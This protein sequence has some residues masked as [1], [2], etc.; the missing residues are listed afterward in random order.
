M[1]S[2]WM[3]RNGFSERGQLEP[4][5][6]KLRS[7]LI[8]NRAAACFG[9]YR[10]SNIS[11]HV[12]CDGAVRHWARY[13]AS[14]QQLPRATRRKIK[15][16][17]NADDPNMWLSLTQCP[18]Q[19]VVKC[20]LHPSAISWSA[21]HSFLKASMA[22]FLKASKAFGS[23]MAF[24]SYPSLHPFFSEVSW[25]CLSH[26]VNTNIT[27]VKIL[28]SCSQY[29]VSESLSITFTTF[30]ITSTQPGR[31]NKSWF[32]SFLAPS[33]TQGRTFKALSPETLSSTQ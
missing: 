10:L 26:A 31:Q 2:A 4:C 21:L 32:F 18:S 33:T 3:C 6:C 22:T 24:L 27:W 28:K 25:P 29:K 8:P 19:V 16:K 20:W 12:M 9:W 13:N 7:N 14:L 11:T 17:C 5:Q 1:L 23:L 15:M 30:K